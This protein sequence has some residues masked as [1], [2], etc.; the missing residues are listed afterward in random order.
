[1]LCIVDT[2]IF[3]HDPKVSPQTEAFKM[4]YSDL[5]KRVQYIAELEDRLS[6]DGI[7]PKDLNSSEVKLLKRKI[8]LLDKIGSVI[9]MHPEKFEEILSI[10]EN[11][12]PGQL[13]AEMKF[14]QERFLAVD[15]GKLLCL[16]FQYSSSCVIIIVFL[17]IYY[18]LSFQSQNCHEVAIPS[19]LPLC[20]IICYHNNDDGDVSEVHTSRYCVICPDPASF[21]ASPCQCDFCEG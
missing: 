19:R 11:H 1:M 10:L 18:M 5:L 16:P 6:S 17:I 15:T 8:N 20:H 7:V 21:I 3:L 14:L 13:I 12:V 9:T 4:V 2:K